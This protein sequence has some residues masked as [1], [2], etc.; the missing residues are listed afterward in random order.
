[1]KPIEGDDQIEFAASYVA[2]RITEA[3]EMTKSV[4]RQPESNLRQIFRK[5]K[6]SRPPAANCHYP[7]FGR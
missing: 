7:R 6:R 3:I 5:F 4:T 1:M 2:D